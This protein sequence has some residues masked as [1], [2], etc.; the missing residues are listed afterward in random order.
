ML[1]EAEVVKLDSVAELL[2]EADEL[3]AITASSRITARKNR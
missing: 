3:T 2:V 1:V